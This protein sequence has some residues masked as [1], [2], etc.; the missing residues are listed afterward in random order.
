MR[1]NGRSCGLE[2]MISAAFRHA[3]AA[4]FAPSVVRMPS[5]RSVL[6]RRSP[7]TRPVV[8]VTMQKM[9]PT[10]PLSSRTGS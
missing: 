7:T 1:P 5:S 6:S 8:S 9:P 2:A 4:D 3:S 10:R